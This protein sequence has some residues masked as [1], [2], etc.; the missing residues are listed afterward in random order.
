MNPKLN[1]GLAKRLTKVWDK[2]FFKTASH[3]ANVAAKH[4]W[5]AVA[6]EMRHLHP[7]NEVARALNIIRGDVW[8]YNLNTTDK[9]VAED[10]RNNGIPIRW[11]EK[12]GKF[13]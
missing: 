2:A 7:G 4:G 8:Y 3:D 6:K 11:N 5:Q 13:V 9:D 1:A 10:L 12:K